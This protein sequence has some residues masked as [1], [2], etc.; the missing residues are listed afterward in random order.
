M[1]TQS[2]KTDPHE[3]PPTPEHVYIILDWQE[4]G[5]MEPNGNRL[6]KEE[7][8]IC[9]P[10]DYPQKLPCHNPDCK[11]GGFGIGSRIAAFLSTDKE[12]E[13]NSLICNNAVQQGQSKRCLHTILYSLTRVLPYKYQK[14]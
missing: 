14:R 6:W 11:N 2:E 3:T 13:Q 9:T 12:R 1:K 7:R 8:L 4:Q 5:P 10:D